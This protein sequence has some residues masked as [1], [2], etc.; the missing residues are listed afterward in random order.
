MQP[1]IQ[2]PRNSAWV[3]EVLKRELNLESVSMC[4]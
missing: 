2:D 4:N 1:Q 3:T